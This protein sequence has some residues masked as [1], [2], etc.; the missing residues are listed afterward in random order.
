[1]ASDADMNE[2]IAKNE[3]LI[4]TINKYNVKSHM[5][6]ANVILCTS[7]GIAW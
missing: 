6:S 2:K 1:M 4:H 7:N 5:A 3:I